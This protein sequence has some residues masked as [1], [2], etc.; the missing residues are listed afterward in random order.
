MVGG[1]QQYKVP[2][3]DLVRFKLFYLLPSFFGLGFGIGFEVRDFFPVDPG[4]LIC[5]AGVFYR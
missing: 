4:E 1:M 5:P 3:L 2:K